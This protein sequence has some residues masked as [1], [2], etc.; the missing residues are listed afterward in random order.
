MVCLEGNQ[1][2]LPVILTLQLT[3]TW[4]LLGKKRHYTITCLTPK[5]YKKLVFLYEWLLITDHPNVRYASP[6][7]S[8][9]WMDREVGKSGA[10]LPLKNISFKIHINPY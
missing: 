9:N 7:F 1:A 2:L 8:L 6:M 5:R 10:W 3:R 4:L